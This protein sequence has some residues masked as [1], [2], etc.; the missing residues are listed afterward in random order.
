MAALLLG[1]ALFAQKPAA[2]PVEPPEEDPGLAPRQYSFNPVQAQKEINAGNFYFKKGNYH[3]AAMRYIEATQWDSG[4]TEALL[5]LGESW[6][7]MKDYDSA[8]DAYTKYLA[9]AD[10]AKTA[11]S[12]KKKMAKWPKSKSQ[13]SAKAPPKTSPK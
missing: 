7:K 1:S 5:K 11:E 8:R 4:S 6:E 12:V 9:I 2:Q 3:A 13:A 10:D